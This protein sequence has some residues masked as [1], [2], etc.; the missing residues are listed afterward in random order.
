MWG[1]LI[2]AAY[3]NLIGLPNKMP[4]MEW[5][6]H[7]NVFLIVLEVGNSKISVL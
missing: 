5:L 6:K 4:Q 7:T 3:F 1:G 2:D